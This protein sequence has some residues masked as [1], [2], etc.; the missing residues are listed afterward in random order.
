MFLRNLSSIIGKTARE[1]AKAP[2]LSSRY[3]AYRVTNDQLQI[4]SLEVMRNQKLVDIVFGAYALCDPNCANRSGYLSL[5]QQTPNYFH[6]FPLNASDQEQKYLM[7]QVI[8]PALHDCIFPFFERCFNAEAAFSE[9]IQMMNRI[10]RARMDQ[11]ALDHMHDAAWVPLSKRI[12]LSSELFYLAMRCSDEKFM[13]QHL[14]ARIDVCRRAI[15]DALAHLCSDDTDN[16]RYYQR[17]ND[18]F[19]ER[20]EQLKRLLKTIS[21]SDSLSKL[22][23]ENERRTLAALPRKISQQTGI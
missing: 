20:A 22:I 17:Q 2:F 8:R 4:I 3:R 5:S 18:R 10:E 14:N 1:C 6:G 23:S 21:D 9:S 15:D 7:E 13:R 12:E 19:S 16:V 11:L